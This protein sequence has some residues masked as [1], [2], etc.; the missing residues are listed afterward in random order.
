M[1]LNGLFE[2]CE[3]EKKRLRIVLDECAP[4]NIL[5]EHCKAFIEMLIYHYKDELSEKESI[6]KIIDA[7]VYLI[8]VADDSINSLSKKWYSMFGVKLSKFR[9]FQIQIF[10]QFLEILEFQGI[11][12]NS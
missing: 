2:G 1:A 10:L 5:L 12:R 7:D 9:C 3:K 6:S 4:A 11:P 8:A